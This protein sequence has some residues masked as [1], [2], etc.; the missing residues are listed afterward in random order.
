MK[1]HWETIYRA[2][3]KVSF[4]RIAKR[5]L[6]QINLVSEINQAFDVG[7][8][9]F[10]TELGCPCDVRFT[11]VSDRTADIAGC[12]KSA[13]NRHR[14]FALRVTPAIATGVTDRLWRIGYIVKVLEDWEESQ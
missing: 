8:G 9:S 6:I 2:S 1:K 7:C 12:L 10:S 3:L 13:N 11:P 4:G 14:P 5:H